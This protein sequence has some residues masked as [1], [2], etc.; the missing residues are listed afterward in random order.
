MAVDDLPDEI[1][2]LNRL[3]KNLISKRIL[4]KK[5][6]IMP[7]GQQPKIKG[8][9]CNIPIRADAVSECLPRGAD[10]D[11]VVIVKLKR[12]LM[13]HGH[14]Y[15]ENVRPGFVNNVLHFL[16]SFN[17]FYSNILIQL[18]N[19]NREMLSL[20]EPDAIVEQD[21]FPITVENLED[22]NPLDNNRVNSGEMCVIPNKD[23]AQ[24][25]LPGEEKSPES[26]FNSDFCEE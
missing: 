2:A 15:F 12:K 22:E 24:N 8:S 14:V 13:F 11:G 16:K 21:E 25:V 6:S 17:P 26:F 20:S 23:K 3:E 10:N 7:K 19:I 4:F 9:V 1:S 18:D 5:I